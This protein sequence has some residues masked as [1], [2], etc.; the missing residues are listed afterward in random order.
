[1][2]FPSVQQ[3]GQK[4]EKKNK[5]KIVCPAVSDALYS[6][7]TT[8]TGTRKA[9]R[10]YKDVRKN[11]GRLVGGCG[12]FSCLFPL[13]QQTRIKFSW[14]KPDFLPGTILAMSWSSERWRFVNNE[15]KKKKT[16]FQWQGKRTRE[17]NKVHDRTVES[18]ARVIFVAWGYSW[19]P[20]GLRFFF[21]R[22]SNRI[23]PLPSG[24][25]KCNLLS[26]GK[27]KL[28]LLSCSIFYYTKSYT[29]ECSLAI[30]KLER[31]GQLLQM[32]AMGPTWARTWFELVGEARTN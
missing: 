24:L 21:R 5:I 4:F 26:E 2:L 23:Y 31:K 30:N 19:P 25:G 28:V 13:W 15:I 32:I 10:R 17:M 11:C 6:T 7:D 9:D 27:N 29:G 16:I 18:V 14:F 3:D 1:M 12:C 8:F 22:D 20:R